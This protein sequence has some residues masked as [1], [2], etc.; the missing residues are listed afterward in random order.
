MR[1]QCVPGPPSSS[2]GLSTR[3]IRS[4]LYEYTL[5]WKKDDRSLAVMIELGT[6]EES[7]D[8][9]MATSLDKNCSPR[10][11]WQLL[12]YGVHCQYEIDSAVIERARTA[13]LAYNRLMSGKLSRCTLWQPVTVGNAQC[14]PRN[15]NSEA[16]NQCLYRKF[17]LFIC[18]HN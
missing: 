16:I 5:T 10:R 7:I 6:N 12:S 11:L 15:L 3:L 17:P 2:K 9:T 8:V 14:G 1:T 4:L 18:I 13:Y